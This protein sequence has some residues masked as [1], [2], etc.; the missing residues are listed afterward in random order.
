MHASVRSNPPVEGMKKLNVFDKK[1]FVGFLPLVCVVKFFK[2]LPQTMSAV[3]ISEISSLTIKQSHN[4]AG[5]WHGETLLST[6]QAGM[7]NV[8]RRALQIIVTCI[9]R[10]GKFS[11]GWR[12]SWLNSVAGRNSRKVFVGRDY[13]LF[14]G[15]TTRPD[16]V[17][18]N[19]VPATLQ[20]MTPKPK[21]DSKEIIFY[22]WWDQHSCHFQWWWLN[23]ECYY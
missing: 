8:F 3:S 13:S 12:I 19:I 18:S 22:T 14:E 2:F 23:F 20:E 21:Y 10:S 9:R 7:I 15:S 16:K 4:A 5:C 1:V 11:I 17:T 6:Y